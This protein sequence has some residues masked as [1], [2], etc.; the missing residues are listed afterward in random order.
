MAR[1][2]QNNF[3]NT[4]Q[5][6]EKR[7]TYSTDASQSIGRTTNLINF[8]HGEKIFYGR[9]DTLEMPISLMDQSSLITIGRSVDITSPQRALKFVVL[10]FNEMALNFEKAV[11]SGQ[12]SGGEKYL[13]N[14]K[15]YK[16]FENP[17]LIYQKEYKKVYFDNI[18]N[19]FKNE[20]GLSNQIKDMNTFIEILFTYLPGIL[21]KLPMTFAGFMK[22]RFCDIM[23]TGLAIELSDLSYSD[24]QS[25]MNHFINNINW[26]Y[27]VNACNAYGFMIDERYPWRIVADVNSDLMIEAAKKHHIFGG[28]IM[29]ETLY[30]KA[31]VTSMKN[32]LKDLIQLY[33]ACRFP[34]YVEHY[35][36]PNGTRKRKT[37]APERYIAEADFF[38]EANVTSQRLIHLYMIIRL[39]EQKPN[40]D[41]NEKNILIK[42]CLRLMANRRSFSLSLYL[43]E[44]VIASTFD[45][46]GSFSYNVKYYRQILLNMFDRGEIEA[47]NME[48]LVETTNRGGY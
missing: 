26:K 34:V 45:R 43:F 39:S 23:K 31:H 12:I 21:E 46:P 41:E 28:N 35:I 15:V 1:Y 17:W 42:D 36:C 37:K 6:Y 20:L 48:D 13:S 44:S 9:M 7:I 5:L 19:Q 27:Y 2:L 10:A 40:M 16:G 3:E 38:K 25:K 11:M 24:D 30:T 22:S 47:I 8:N 32:F 29:F 4:R 33:N 14:L 18:A